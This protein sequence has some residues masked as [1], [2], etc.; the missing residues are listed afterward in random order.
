[1]LIPKRILSL[2]SLHTPVDRRTYVGTGLTL[3]ALK[4]T[5]D[6]AVVYAS[7]GVFWHPLDYLLPMLS[8][9]DSKL[10]AISP[11]VGLALLI[12]TIPFVW[13]GVLLSVR[14]AWDAGLPPWIAVAFFIPVLNYALM[15]TLATSPTR[16]RP[17]E[18]PDLVYEHARQSSRRSTIAGVLAGALA[19]LLAVIVGVQFIKSYGLTVFLGTPFVVGL[20]SGFV[21][22]RIHLRGHGDTILVAMLALLLTSLG[23]LIFAT[24]GLVCIAMALPIAA[25]LAVL[26]GLVGQTLAARRRTT[27]SGMALL[28]A[29]L[30]AGSLLDRVFEVPAARVVTTVVD[31]DAPPA[32]VWRHVVSFGR[33]A[34]APQWYFRTGLAYPLQAR[35]EGTGVGAVRYCE[36]STGAFREPITAWEERA[37]LAFDVTDQPAPLQEWS[38]WSKVYAPH[39]K[40]FFQTTRGEFRLTALPSGRTRLEGHTWY[41]LRIY[42]SAY[43][44]PITE[45]I[46]HRIHE[47]VLCHVKREAERDRS[48][49]PDQGGLSP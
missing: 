32:V 15:F 10:G 35:I 46:L 16:V 7:T 33:I 37:R 48:I 5:V 12:W 45:A 14:R 31:V 19:A 20:V 8:V 9:W 30:P 22:N 21:A 1:M 29:L 49:R 34:E 39:L 47:R 6:A 4:Y 25:P 18:P 43:W 42:P 41:L 40:G 2:F 28:V 23:L 27:T 44:T 26:G 24:E 11:G 17:Q 13:A 38:P 3:M 36:F